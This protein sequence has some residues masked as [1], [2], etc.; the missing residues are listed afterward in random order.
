M[1]LMRRRVQ[2]RWRR[3]LVFGVVG[4]AI[5]FLAD[6]AGW[7][8]NVQPWGDPRP[9]TDVWWHFPV[10]VAVCFALTLLWPFRLDDYDRI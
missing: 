2:Q 1:R 10:F 8:G 9:L 3:A 5:V 4:G 7:R 6:W